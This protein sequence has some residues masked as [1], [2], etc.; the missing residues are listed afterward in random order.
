MPTMVEQEELLWLALRMTPQLGARRTVDI[1]EKFGSPSAI[2]QLEARDLEG[3]GL[4]MGVARSIEAG[5]AMD[6][7]LEQQRLMRA[8]GTEMVTYFDDR[9]PTQLKQIYD[10]PALLFARAHGCDCGDA[11]A[12]TLREQCCGPFCA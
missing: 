6:D 10:P 4:S 8:T 3:A 2:F 11:E 5:A 1:L 9:Y 7:A 12:F